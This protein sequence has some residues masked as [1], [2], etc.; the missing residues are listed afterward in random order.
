[1]WISKSSKWI[2]HSLRKLLI[3]WEIPHCEL[4]AIPRY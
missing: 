3:G 4:F 1:M 2:S